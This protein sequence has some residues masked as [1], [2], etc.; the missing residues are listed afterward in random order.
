MTWGH[1]VS[2]WNRKHR[3]YTDC[4]AYF[5][6][7]L[8]EFY[9]ASFVWLHRWKHRRTRDAPHAFRMVYTI[10]YCMHNAETNCLVAVCLDN[11]I[12]ML[13]EWMNRERKKNAP[14]PPSH[15]HTTENLHNYSIWSRLNL[16][17]CTLIKFKRVKRAK[18]YRLTPMVETTNK[19][20]KTKTRI[21]IRL[22]R[23]EDERKKKRW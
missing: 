15:Y 19:Q 4:L 20:N 10:L 2:T 9:G 21:M 5:R 7:M 11:I 8:M 16:A 14:S 12:F 1:I 6:W 3:I 18:A 17:P 23:N 13:S 22:M